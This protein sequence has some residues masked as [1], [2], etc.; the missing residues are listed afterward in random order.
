MY[1]KFCGYVKAKVNVCPTGGWIEDFPDPYSVLFVPFSG[2]AI[3]P[4]NNANSA[5][6]QRSEGE[7]R[8]RQRGGDPRARRRASPRSRK[9]TR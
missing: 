4:I 1:T 9:R 7:L 5:L 3:V 2:K 8:D 6:A